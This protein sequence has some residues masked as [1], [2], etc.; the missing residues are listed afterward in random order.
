MAKF[1]NNTKDW[2]FRLIKQQLNGNKEAIDEWINKLELSD[3]DF[4]KFL[5]D[6][7]GMGDILLHT[8]N[9]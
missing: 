6:W 8:S 4:K 7:D 3:E 1:I 2:D 5:K 9:G